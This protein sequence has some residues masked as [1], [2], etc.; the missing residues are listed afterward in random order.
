MHTS[1][2]FQIDVITNCWKTHL[3]YTDPEEGGKIHKNV[4]HTSLSDTKMS[5][6]API[7]PLSQH[8]GWGGGS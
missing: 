4:P 1:D 8:G 2:I 3:G 7:Y 6:A 5:A